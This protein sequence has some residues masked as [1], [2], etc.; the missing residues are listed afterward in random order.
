MP[1]PKINNIC[2]SDIPVASSLTTSRLTRWVMVQNSNN[3]VAALSNADIELTHIATVD[4]SLLKLMAK[5]AA[6][7]KIGLPG[8]CPTS[9]L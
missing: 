9:S 5:R 4:G 2:T 6:N 8:G 7:M 1:L 3:M